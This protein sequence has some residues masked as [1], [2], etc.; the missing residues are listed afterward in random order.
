MRKPPPN[1][2]YFPMTPKAQALWST[3]ASGISGYIAYFIALP[4]SLQTGMLGQIVQLVPVPYQPVVAGTTK[5]L[6]TFLAFY[7]AYKLS[8]HNQPVPPQV[9]PAIPPQ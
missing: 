8:H 9:S 7:A 5:T 3:L 1:G 4:L 2:T 6:S